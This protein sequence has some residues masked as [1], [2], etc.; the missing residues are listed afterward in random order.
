MSVNE[1]KVKIANAI[2]ILAVIAVPLCY[3][4]WMWC[5]GTIHANNA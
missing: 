3:V 4:L 1:K 5:G 2:V